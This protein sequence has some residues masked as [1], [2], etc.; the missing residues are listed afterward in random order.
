MI[1]VYY[2]FNKLVFTG[3]LYTNRV[4]WNKY[5]Q[6]EEEMKWLWK[7]IA[8]QHVLE[9]LI[10]MIACC[11][12]YIYKKITSIVDASDIFIFLQLNTTFDVLSL[13]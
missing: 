10:Y 11:D 8:N 4:W 12:Q 2:I 7:F 3:A 9:M 6:I 1:S 5:S 13:L